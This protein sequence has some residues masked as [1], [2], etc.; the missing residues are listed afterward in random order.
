MLDVE[1]GADVSG[2]IRV[3]AQTTE[4]TGGTTN[5]R[6]VVR[7]GAEIDSVTACP[8]VFAPSD[9]SL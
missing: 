8:G 2:T 6:I 1:T 9:A 7:D 3:G 4:L 5:A